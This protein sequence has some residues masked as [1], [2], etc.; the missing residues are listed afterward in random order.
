[1]STKEPCPD[2]LAHMQRIQP[3]SPQRNGGGFFEWVKWG[4]LLHPKIPFHWTFEKTQKSI[5]PLKIIHR[6]FSG[7]NVEI[8][9]WNL[10]WYLVGFSWN[11]KSHTCNPANRREFLLNHL[12]WGCFLLKKI[13]NPSLSLTKTGRM[14]RMTILE[15]PFYLNESKMWWHLFWCVYFFKIFSCSFSG[16]QY[17]SRHKKNNDETTTS[18]P[19][20]ISHAPGI[21]APGCKSSGR[22]GSGKYLSW[23]IS[24]FRILFLLLCKFW[25]VE[26]FL[27]FVTSK[28]HF[29]DDGGGGGDDDSVVE[30]TLLCK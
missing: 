16:F 18:Q 11:N 6:I 24:F 29:D 1:M 7:K 22:S 26:L 4:T 21:P 5:D 14:D 12:H 28:V 3:E 23:V 19:R 27:H 20:V 9:F 17:S 13:W 8:L 10:S 15:W 25:L 2:L 30:R